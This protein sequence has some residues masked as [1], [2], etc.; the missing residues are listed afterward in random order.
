MHMIHYWEYDA[1]DLIFGRTRMADYH[2]VHH[3]ELN[4][5]IAAV[6]FLSDDFFVKY[7]PDLK[8]YFPH[9]FNVENS[10]KVE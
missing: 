10:K 3:N 7:A 4:R 2:N 8:P 1:I 9:L 5:N 6:G